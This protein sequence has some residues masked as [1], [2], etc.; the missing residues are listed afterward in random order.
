MTDGTLESPS[1]TLVD[2][3]IIRLQ[4]W[5]GNTLITST[6]FRANYDR[7]YATALNSRLESP[8][9]ISAILNGSSKP[10]IPCSVWYS[11]DAFVELEWYRNNDDH[12]HRRLDDWLRELCNS[13]WSNYPTTGWNDA[14]SGRSNCNT[15][16]I[17][18]YLRAG[19]LW[20][21]GDNTFQ[22]IPSNIVSSHY[23]V[24]LRS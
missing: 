16:F 7:T 11:I 19:S 6:F 8:S 24:A 9:M 14:F 23:F 21:C 15:V 13:G 20:Y 3:S 4:N 1:L 22:I 10:L 2:G 18:R 12:F 17:R 5:I